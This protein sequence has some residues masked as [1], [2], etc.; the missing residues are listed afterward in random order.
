MSRPEFALAALILTAA[1]L[2]GGLA[3]IV[4]AA[5]RAAFASLTVIVLVLMAL[6][7]IALGGRPVFSLKVLFIAIAV[8]AIWFMTPLA[9]GELGQYF[10]LG[11]LLTLAITAPFLVVICR[12]K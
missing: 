1:G 11:E 7:L 8:A 2:A 5:T 4:P 10:L 12:R 3:S 9:Y 6:V